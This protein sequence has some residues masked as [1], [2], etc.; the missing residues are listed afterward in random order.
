MSKILVSGLLNLETTAKTRGF[1]IQYYPVDYPFF[2]VSST[3]SGV[4][5]NVAKALTGLGDSISLAS[6]IGKDLTADFFLSEIKKLGISADLVLQ[7]LR[8]T[9]ASVILYDDSGRRQIYCDLKDIQETEHEFS[10]KIIDDADAVVACNINFSRPLLD[11]AKSKNK[12]VATDVHVL[13]NIDDEYNREFME[14]ADILFLSDEG[15]SWSKHDFVRALGERYRNRII[16][17]GM[18]AS[19]AL[20]HMP[21]ENIMVE[22][23]AYKIDNVVNTVGAG[24]ALFSAFLHYYL[25]GSDPVHALDCAQMFAALKIRKA[26]AADGFVSEKELESSL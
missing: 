25:K 21:K 11:M 24:D 22:R 2:G 23:P 13:S 26:S 9:P 15:I 17:L 6:L 14:K 16:V 1:P 20:L 18:G 10:E 12:L 5:F 7:K 4:A 3:L 19:G 8:E